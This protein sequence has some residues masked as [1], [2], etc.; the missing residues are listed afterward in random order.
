MDN[1]INQKVLD[2]LLKI[3]NSLFNSKSILNIDEVSEFT[4]IS[5]STL[6]KLTS[7]REIPH[8]KKA[9]HLIFDKTEIEDWLKSNKVYTSEEIEREAS[10]YISLNKMGGNHE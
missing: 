4:G 7:N 2:S 8:Y 5:K 1:S 6:Y 10:T 9:K 3:E